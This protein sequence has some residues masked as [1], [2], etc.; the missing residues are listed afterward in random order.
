MRISSPTRSPAPG[1]ADQHRDMGPL[2]RYLGPLILSEELPWQDVFLPGQ[3]IALIDEEDAAALKAR[4]GVGPVGGA[5]GLGG[6][7]AASTFRGLTSA[8][9]PMAR[10]SALRRRSDWAVNQPAESLAKVLDKLE[11]IRKAFNALQT[12]SKKVSLKPILIVLGGGALTEK[13]AG[14]GASRFPS[15]RRMDA[16]AWSR[17]TSTFAPLE[18]TAD[19]FRNYVSGATAHRRGSAGRPRA[20]ADADG[21]RR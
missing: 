1:A 17:P 13:A 18:P 21:R 2:V 5:A 9:A 19:G 11:A 8:A 20:T 12:G 3:S 14:H 10:A 16:S 15:R 6:G 7:G 4:F